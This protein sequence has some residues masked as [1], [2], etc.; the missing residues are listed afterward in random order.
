[1]PTCTLC[2]TV[3]PVKNGHSQ[4]HPK[5][6]FKTNYCLMQVKSIAE[7]SPWSILQYFRP[8]LG[9]HLSLI[10]LFCLF[11]SSCFTQIL[12][13]GPQCEKTCLGGVANNT[14]ADQPMHPRSLISVFD[15]RF[16]ERIICK[17]ATSEISIFLASL[18]S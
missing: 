17:L 11:L 7:C 8:S 16:L 9:C 13:Y 1:M 14:G 15:I 12:L 3:K 6:V 18:C 5:L 4:K 2:C 10:L